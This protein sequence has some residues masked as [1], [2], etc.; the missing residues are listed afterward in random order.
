MKGKKFAQERLKKGKGDGTS[1]KGRLE[2]IISK[3]LYADDPGLY[4][5][6][7]REFDRVERCNLKEF[8]ERSGNFSVIPASRIIRI[9]KEGELLFEKGR[10]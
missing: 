9:T 3:A 2:E 8:L 5:V 7:Y 4:T 1:M 10:K 6:E